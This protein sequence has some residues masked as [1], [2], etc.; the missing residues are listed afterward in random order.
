MKTGLVPHLITD[1]TRHAALAQE[2]ADADVKQVA[3]AHLAQCRAAMQ[4][5][6]R[7]VK[8]GR[9]PDA[10]AECAEVESLLARLPAPLEDTPLL[11]DLKVRTAFVRLTS[12][13]LTLWV[14]FIPRLKRPDRRTAERRV[15]AKC[16]SQ[17]F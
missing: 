12:R 6:E 4:K 8:D 13:Q 11:T 15:F 5:L 16:G 17:W 14:A 3:I 9:L 10:M 7:L 1:L 2:T